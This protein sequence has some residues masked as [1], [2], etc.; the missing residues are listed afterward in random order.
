MP[1][2]GRSGSRVGD[3]VG[4]EQ[5]FKRR[6]LPQEVQ[7]IDAFLYFLNLRGGDHH[8]QVLLLEPIHQSLGMESPGDEDGQGRDVTLSSL[9]GFDEVFR[10]GLVPRQRGSA[11]I[12]GGFKGGG[13][14]RVVCNRPIH[15]AVRIICSCP[16][17]RAVRIICSCP[18]HR[19][20]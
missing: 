15:R 11:K 7:V 12:F 10:K 9:H 4:R 5:L 8:R 14:I 20:V 3:G 13:E 18:I 19:A 17:H 16:I 1:G 2:E 6:L